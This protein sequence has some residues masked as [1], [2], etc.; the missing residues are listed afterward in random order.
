MVVYH[1]DRSLQVYDV[2]LVPL[3]VSTVLDLF[4]NHRIKQFL[5]SATIRNPETFVTFLKACGL[6]YFLRPFFPLFP[7]YPTLSVYKGVFSPQWKD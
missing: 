1:S 4:D 2:D 7:S 3:L 6:N 5:I